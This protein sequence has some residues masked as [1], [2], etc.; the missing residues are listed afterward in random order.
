MKLYTTAEASEKTG[1]PQGTIRS[2][3]T[4]HSELFQVETHVQIDEHGKICNSYNA[5]ADTK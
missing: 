3:L 2:W 1:I 5:Q 4:R